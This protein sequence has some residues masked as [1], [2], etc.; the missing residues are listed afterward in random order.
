MLH[1]VW[2]QFAASD[3]GQSYQQS[4]SEYTTNDN[5]TE[6][7][8]TTTAASNSFK[9]KFKGFVNSVDE[10][11]KEVVTAIK[12]KVNVAIDKIKTT[13]DSYKHSDSE[14]HE[15]PRDPDSSEEIVGQVKENH[16][17]PKKSRTD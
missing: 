14:E 12:K 1:D 3:D 15:V 5:E 17:K 13:Y 11:R 4:L 7:P 8:P 16:E 6:S 9:D 2:L 10:K